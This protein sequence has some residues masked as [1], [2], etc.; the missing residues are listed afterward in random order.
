[1]SKSRPTFPYTAVLVLLST[2]PS[3]DKLDA[4]FLGLKMCTVGATYGVIASK[5]S[6]VV[7]ERQQ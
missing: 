5:I 7:H 6:D 1:M 4:R 3:Q 2:K